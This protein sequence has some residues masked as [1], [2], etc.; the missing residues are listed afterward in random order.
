M[1]RLII[2]TV[3]VI[4]VFICQRLPTPLQVVDDL[5]PVNFIKIKMK[6]V[7]CF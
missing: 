1:M 2:S 6:K 4:S 3:L 5:I 7:K